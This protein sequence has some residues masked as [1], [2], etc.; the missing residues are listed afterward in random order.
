MYL[1]TANKSK[2]NSKANLPSNF[3]TQKGLYMSENASAAHRVLEYLM[4][5]A[6]LT[7]KL[8]STTIR[9]PYN[10]LAASCGAP[11]KYKNVDLLVKL[12]FEWVES[13][14][15][16]LEIDFDTEAGESD[17]AK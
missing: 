5:K 17:G 13:G 9:V 15:T 16:E 6:A 10:E 11:E 7:G 8:K 1:E 12:D 3:Y 14:N 2:F 4:T